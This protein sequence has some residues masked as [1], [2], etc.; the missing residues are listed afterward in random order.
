[1]RDK[2]AVR[3]GDWKLVL[4]GKQEPELYNLRSDIGESRNLAD[5]QPEMKS[6]LLRELARWEADVDGSR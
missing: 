5:S 2:K 1:M 4:A 6:K 3:Q